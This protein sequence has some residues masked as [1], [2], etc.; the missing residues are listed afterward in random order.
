L[1][2]R[3]PADR[4][5]GRLLTA[6][7]AAEVT[8]AFEGAM[9]F[10]AML[11]VIQHYGDANLAG[12]LVSAYMIG[13]AVAAPLAGRLGDLLGRRRILV[14]VLAL[15]LAGS[16]LSAASQAFGAVV[17]GRLLQG[18]S[19]AAL[20]LSLG[21][22]REELPQTRVPL[23]VGLLIAGAV[24]GGGSGLLV[25]GYIVDH[26]SWP[27]LFWASSVMGL[28]SLAACVS[29]V[30][31]ST[32]PGL[33]KGA[34]LASSFM[35][36]PALVIL[37]LVISNVQRLGLTDPRIGCGLAISIAIFIYWWRSER[38]RRDPLIDVRLLQNREIGV[39]NV[40]VALSAVGSMQGSQLFMMLLQQPAWTG[41][42]LGLTATVA[43]ALKFPSNIVAI[44]ASAGSGQLSGK[45]GARK[46][47]ILGASTLTLGW[48]GLLFAHGSL[49]AVIVLMMLSLGG[50]A[51]LFVGASTAV[52]AA[53][54]HER[55]SEAAG[56]LTLNRAVFQAVGAQLMLALLATSEVRDSAGKLYASVN[57]YRL[58]FLF[59]I[60]T[61]LAMVVAAS[62]L[63]KVRRQS[64]PAAAD[65]APSD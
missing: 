35:F 62:Y 47:V 32:A 37:L 44:L 2:K 18:L 30:P 24:I 20:P 21:I 6:L 61:C 54:P 65:A 7:I 41:V 5:G 9:I 1:A 43:A 58:V 17:L 27:R 42:G 53:A 45:L 38:R 63:H 16:L 25:G 46:V 52:V 12:W 10:A 14:T 60:A 49:T 33:H 57:G 13:A 48:I 51:V 15:G 28:L 50:A 39:A 34:G 31:G 59:M 22:I 64:P 4:G 40:C 36:A 8:A 3:T 55:T 19:G 23:G 56:M 29:W 11:K 26:F